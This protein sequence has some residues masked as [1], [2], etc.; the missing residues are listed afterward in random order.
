MG[1]S[2]IPTT[3]L[4]GNEKLDAYCEACTLPH[5]E[6][7]GNAG[8]LMITRDDERGGIDTQAIADLIREVLTA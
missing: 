7:G 6:G 4:A 8:T 5:D 1:C 3:R 2:I